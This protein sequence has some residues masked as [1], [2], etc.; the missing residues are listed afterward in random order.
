MKRLITDCPNCRHPMKIASLKC[1][2]CGLELRND[3]DPSPFDLLSDDHYGF[4]MAFLRNKGNLK[5]L[6]GELK[7]S[8]PLAKKKLDGLLNALGLEN[9]DGSE[10]T[11]EA[12]DVSS[13][14]VDSGSNRASEIIKA[15]LK[16]SGGRV[17]VQTV[18]GLPCEITACSDGCSFTS[19]KLPIKPPFRYEIFDIITDLLISKGGRARKG[20]GRNNRFGHPDCDE[21]TVVGAIAKAYFNKKPGD[22]VFDPVFVLAAVLEWAGIVVNARGEL[23]LTESYRSTL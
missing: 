18:T 4:L 1:P 11:K 19:D 9:S 10:R 2:E 17:Y 5:G 23:V 3:F 13:I 7:I 21:S 16:Q 12:V 22:S 14:V 20:N 6:Q 8:Y 15:K